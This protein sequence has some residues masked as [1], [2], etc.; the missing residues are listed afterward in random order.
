MAQD[1]SSEDEQLQ[2]HFL[3][4]QLNI[5]SGGGRVIFADENQARERLKSVRWPIRVIC[6]RCGC[7]DVGLIEKR[8]TYYCR[9]CKYQFTVTTSTVMHRSHLKVRTWFKAAKYIISCHAQ[10]RAADL[11]TADQ[12][13]NQIN[14]TYKVAYRIRK[15]LLIELLQSG[16]GT[17]GRCIC[18]RTFRL[19]QD[20]EPMSSQHLQ[21]L[22]KAVSI[23]HR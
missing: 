15:V 2:I 20:I 23:L 3:T 1:I 22:K 17:V 4:L 16:G 9:E 11:L 13:K 7:D 21:W 18:P 19:P 12:L 8:K 14:V 6:L 5:A 10:G